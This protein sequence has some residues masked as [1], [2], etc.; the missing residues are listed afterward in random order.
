MSR[1]S[2]YGS[3]FLQNAMFSLYFFWKGRSHHQARHIF[4]RVHDL[5]IFPPF[6]RGIGCEIVV[7]LFSFGERIL[8]KVHKRDS[9]AR[10]RNWNVL[11]TAYK[12]EGRP[13]QF[14]SHSG[15]MRQSSRTHLQPQEHEMTSIRRERQRE[16]GR[17]L[18]K[19]EEKRERENVYSHGV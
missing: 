17:E 6:L 13:L 16:G 18:I 2:H 7:H 3:P 15:E 10:T 1:W 12:A 4:C 8:C 9:R 14:I 19:R 11:Y 5:S